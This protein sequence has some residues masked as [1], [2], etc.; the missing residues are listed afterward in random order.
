MSFF[1]VLYYLHYSSA[2]ALQVLLVPIVLYVN[3]EFL[4]PNIWSLLHKSGLFPQYED[5]IPNPFAPFFLLSHRVPTSSPDD[6]RY[7]KGYLDLL[8]VAY[9]VVF[10][11]LMRQIIAVNIAGH[12]ARRVGIR[13]EAK[14]ER[15]GEQ[16]YA[17][18]YWGSS[19]SFTDSVLVLTYASYD[20]EL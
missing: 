20:R 19:S 11:S 14:V 4:S 5:G 15:F 18:F 12:F 2:S 13:R 8:F 6:P 16:V 3:W 1:L 9:Y 7:Q 10:W 17:I